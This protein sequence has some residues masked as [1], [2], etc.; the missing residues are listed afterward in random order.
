M[1]SPSASLQQ[2]AFEQ[3]EMLSVFKKDLAFLLDPVMLS[4]QK[5]FAVTLF[6]T[7][8]LERI[9]TYFWLIK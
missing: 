5:L 2:P 7:L 9:L 1:Q 6:H 4:F 8:T 3:S